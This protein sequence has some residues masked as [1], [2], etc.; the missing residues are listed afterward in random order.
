MPR[1]RL[2]L[3]AACLAAAGLAVSA[4]QTEAPPPGMAAYVVGFLKKGAAWTGAENPTLRAGHLA[5]L[6]ALVVAGDLV[7]VGPFTDG[8]I[9]RGVFLFRATPDEAQAL[10][11]EDPIVEID[12]LR[13]ELQPWMATE[14][15][16]PASGER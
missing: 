7:A 2:L 16:I 15:V 12:R 13:L 8:G 10:A 3:V 5:H 6:R 4:R 9:L 11:A 1:R 14:G